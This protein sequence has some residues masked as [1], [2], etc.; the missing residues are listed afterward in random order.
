M[1][2]IKGY[3][4][5]NSKI[6]TRKQYK[7]AK[8]ARNAANKINMNYGSHIASANPIIEYPEQVEQVRANEQWTLIETSEQL[9][10]TIIGL[11]FNRDNECTPY[12]VAWNYNELTNTWGQG[13][14][15][16]TITNATILYNDY[17]L[18]NR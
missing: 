17:I 16:S 4:V 14:Y 2:T 7:T 8:G 3:E 10:G 1:G 13:H 15:C 18:E 11:L 6:G 5:Y 9:T 12:L